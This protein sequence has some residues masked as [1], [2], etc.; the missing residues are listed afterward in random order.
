MRETSA[1]VPR[2]SVAP[3][4]DCK[5]CRARGWYYATP[6]CEADGYKSKCPACGSTG[7][8][9][10]HPRRNWWR[11]LWAVQ[12]VL[13]CVWAFGVCAGI[14]TRN[15]LAVINV[16]ISIMMA[17]PSIRYVRARAEEE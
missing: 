15:W 17:T 9:P 11:V 16:V 4:V 14:Y 8:V 13:V 12:L 7:R 3:Q 2:A 5:A 1:A 10:A 6:F